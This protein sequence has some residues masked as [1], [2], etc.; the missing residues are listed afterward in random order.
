MPK[1][2]FRLRTLLAV[3]ESVLQE[4]S[5]QLAEVLAAQHALELLQVSVRRELARQQHSLPT[6][7]EQR[8]LDIEHLFA[9]DRYRNVLRVRLGAIAQETAALTDEIDARQRALAAAERE[10]R[11][12]DKL[13]E[14]QLDQFRY[15][16]L[17]R[18]INATDEIAT[19]N[20]LRQKSA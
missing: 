14:H 9:A 20:A 4:R 15:D 2:Q 1:F 10:V 19:R 11:V 16:Q 13:R 8:P 7:A 17:R 12:L 6:A 5:A 3:R 18:E